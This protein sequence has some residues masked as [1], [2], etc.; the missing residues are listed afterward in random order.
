[1][2]QKIYLNGE[3][4][5]RQ[6]AKI[7]V[8][9]HG[10]L[11]GD[12]IFEG[13]RT[14]NGRIFKLAEHMDRLHRSAKYICLD[15]PLSREKLINA[16]LKTA[17]LNGYRDC[18][19]RIV[20]TR[21]EGD[22]GLAPEKCKSSTLFIIVDKIELFSEEFYKKGLE[23]ITVPTQR[24]TPYNL[25]PRVKS[26]NY[27]NNILAK[28]E[29]QNAGFKEAIML[30]REGFVTECTADNIFIVDND[31]IKTPPTYMGALDGITRKTVIEIAK[32]L[33]IEVKEEILARY[34]LFNADEC[35][36]TGT[37]AEIMPVV[38]IDGR[39]IGD[40]KVG[41][42]TNKIRSAYKKLVET[43]GTSYL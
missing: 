40:G 6:E 3:F 37:G 26:L 27:L 16:V 14:Y 39:T 42:T 33:S 28:I 21:G 17:Q 30:N 7:S 29:A 41:N 4:V 11:Y 1:M 24:N 20:V 5:P 36:L 9:D 10:L 35:F 2:E 13:L 18:Y 15:I 32:K 22:L 19:V 8:Y 25:D 12:G 43:E 38:K 31:V 23:I 34:D